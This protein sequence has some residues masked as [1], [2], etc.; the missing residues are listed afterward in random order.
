[1]T[2]VTSFLATFITAPMPEL[3]GALGR[4]AQARHRLAVLGG[5]RLLGVHLEGPWIAAEQAGAH[6]PSLMSDPTP[7]HVRALLE[8][9][10][11]L[12]I[13]SMVTLAPERSGA[14]R[15]VAELVAHGVVVSVGHSHATAQQTEAAADAGATM[16]THLF[17]AQRG[18]H[19]REPGVAGHA[20]VDERLTLG[21]IADG[22]HVHPDVLTL[23]LRAAGH[24]VALVT[25][26]AAPTGAPPGRYALGGATVTVDADGL[27]RRDD[28]T[29][30][31]STLRMDD[32]VRTLVDLGIDPAQAL[33]CA[34][35]VPA[36]VLGR[37]DLGRITVGAAADLVWWSDEL[38]VR[39]T[40]V[41]GTP[42]PPP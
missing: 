24:R 3:V 33:R 5:A 37:G 8:G 38:V 2:G 31:G 35:T 32:A 7:A 20:L 28:G 18:L 42:L 41:A 11:G 16:V 27:P 6:D 26:A 15:A 9:D 22:H 23:A 36:D 40:W 1:R 30:A 39:R 25:D 13:L 4:A 19:H 34:S 29:L 10:Y 17:N 21:L 14:L 12:R